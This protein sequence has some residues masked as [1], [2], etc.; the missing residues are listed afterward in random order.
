MGM[1]FRTARS[2][3][4]CRPNCSAEKTL[5]G[6]RNI[7]RVSLGYLE[8]LQMIHMIMSLRI[9]LGLRLIATRSV[10]SF[11][12]HLILAL[13]I[14]LVLR[15]IA[16]RSVHIMV[17]DSS[18]LVQTFAFTLVCLGGWHSPARGEHHV[19]LGVA[20][21]RGLVAAGAMVWAAGPGR[22]W[23]A[24]PCWSCGSMVGSAPRRRTQ[25][26]KKRSARVAAFGR[27]HVSGSNGGP[28][29]PK[30]G[31]TSGRHRPVL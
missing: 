22:V 14:Y 15:L 30:G 12:I 16:T 31:C 11:L 6:S 20:V 21:Q 17:S 10:Q 19:E 5:N 3:G 18:I 1:S 9:Y 29:G 7:K 4:Y 13:R 23:A 25:A 2:N 26:P 24:P 27:G 8:R 28:M